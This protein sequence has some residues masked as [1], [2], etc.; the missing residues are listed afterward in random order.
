MLLLLSVLIVI[1]QVWTDLRIPDYM[2]TITVLVKTEGHEMSE[3]WRAGG[4]MLLC[5]VLAMCLSLLSG[6]V[7]A[8]LAAF[9]SKDLRSDI[10]DAVENFS[11]EEIDRFSTASLITRSTND[12]TQIQ[13]FMSR[14]LRMI[15]T[16][17]ITVTIAMLKIWGKHWQWTSLLGAGVVM[18]LMVV[19]YLI[20]YAHPRFRR[21]QVLTDNLNQVTRENLTGIRVVRAYNAE[22]YMQD[23]FSDANNILTDNALQARRAM[24]LMRPVMRFTNNGLTVGIYCVGAF[25]IA[26]QIGTGSALTT[27]SEMIVFST[28]AQRVLGSFMSLNM[29]FNM[30]PRAAVS[31]ERINE[32][33]GTDPSIKSGTE[34]EGVDGQEGTV[35]FRNV[36]FR[37]P[38]AEDDIL[39]DISFTAKKGETVA[40]IGATGSGK[41]SLVNLVPRFY[42]AGKGEVLVDG[43]NVKE[44]DQTALRKKIG[45]APQRAVLFTGTVESNLKYG[46]YKD[47]DESPESAQAE[48]EKAISIAQAE[49]FVK[50]MR[51][52]YEADIAR[53]GT[54]VSGGQKQRLSIARTVFR[55]PE[56]YIF[57]DTFSA[58]DYKTDRMLR[59]RL[60]KETAG[61]TTLIVAQR[62]GTIRDADKIIVL[63]EGRIV[64]EGT[65]DELMK[66]CSVYKE[67]ALT[68]LSEEE[69]A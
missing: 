8:R 62:I 5:A 58:L 27:F 56:I 68:Q 17:P 43:R 42:D 14:G 65:H 13:N 26:T 47:M 31:A 52:G 34:T 22:G 59:A 41:T 11:L 60:K 35:E 4:M 24:S 1:A 10:F 63:D 40:F 38:A 61:V 64:G 16:A 21:M 53:G 20:K 23:K 19:M 30:L 54:N 39:R 69:L 12:V 67:I 29:I 28:Y 49:D 36:S 6:F 66:N 44:Y 51:G 45:Y 48:M 15:I 50:A 37:Y 46:E 2:T 25:I 32:I 55:R 18:V 7:S 9:F 33:L 57:D 3:I